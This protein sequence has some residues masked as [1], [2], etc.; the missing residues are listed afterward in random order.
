MVGPLV[1]DA[2]LGEERNFLFEAAW[3]CSVLEEPFD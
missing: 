1:E 3:F 2:H